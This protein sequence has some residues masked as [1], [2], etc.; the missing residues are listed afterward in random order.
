MTSMKANQVIRRLLLAASLIGIAACADDLAA[1]MTHGTI[2]PAA[3]RSANNGERRGRPMHSH[4]NAE[5]ADAATPVSCS[6]RPTFV[7]SGRFGPGGGT[8]IV[9]GSALIIPGGALHD[10]VT[11]SATQLGNGTSTIDFQPHGLHFYK[12]A[13][14]AL[15][16]TGC[17]LPR[18][19]SPSVVY[20]GEDGAVLETIQAYY[21]PHWKTVA[22]PIVHFSGYAIAF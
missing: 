17:D 21:D 4:A 5:S 15:D 20:V 7:S 2:R 6:K 12:P 18:G 9:G 13:G 16:A 10:T 19:E 3:S 8:L 1:P 11:I 14:L 22:A